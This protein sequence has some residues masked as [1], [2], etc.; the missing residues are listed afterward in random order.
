M[1]C[2]QDAWSCGQSSEDAIEWFP[3]QGLRA[4][5]ASYTCCLTLPAG[6]AACGRCPRESRPYVHSWLMTVQ[7]MST[8]AAANHSSCTSAHL[9]GHV[10]CQQE[11]L[12]QG[13]S[14]A[15]CTYTQ[16]SERRLNTESQAQAPPS[17][18]ATAADVPPFLGM[19]VARCSSKC[20]S[21]AGPAAQ[22][23]IKWY[24]KWESVM[25]VLGCTAYKPRSRRHP[26]QLQLAR[27]A[28]GACT[29]RLP[30]MCA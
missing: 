1:R 17:T 5:C 7:R 21:Q 28:G 16:A 18:L 14:A 20:P 9:P 23:A 30:S 25:T 10:R 27:N 19:A 3:A 12:P 6:M 15:A 29:Q 8:A 22:Q 24:R 4:H 26:R 11:T 2:L 13:P